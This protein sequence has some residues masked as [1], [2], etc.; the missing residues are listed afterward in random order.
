[1]T[2][3]PSRCGALTGL[4]LLFACATHADDALRD[5]VHRQY[6]HQSYM[7]VEDADGAWLYLFEKGVE[8]LRIGSGMAPSATIDSALDKTLSDHARTRVLGLTALAG[9]AD[10]RALDAALALLND[11]HAAVREEAAQL[12]IDHPQGAVLAAALGLDDESEFP[13]DADG[14]Q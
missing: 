5:E 12:I 4:A 7:L 3:R 2:S 9:V 6:K 1:M 8:P 11:E 13:E 14:G 10:T